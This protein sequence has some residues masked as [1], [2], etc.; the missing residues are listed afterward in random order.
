MRY[1]KFEGPWL[2]TAS[3]PREEDLRRIR[4][5]AARRAE[6]EDENF[7]DPEPWSG[8]AEMTRLL[9]HGLGWAAIVCSV[10]SFCF[11]QDA[12][13]W[14]TYLFIPILAEIVILTSSGATTS[15]R[16]TRSA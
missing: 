8:C 5:E 1:A 10:C 9:V 13:L 2:I 15:A 4:E 7:Y 12:G 14:S 6:E 3:F 11:R 16:Q